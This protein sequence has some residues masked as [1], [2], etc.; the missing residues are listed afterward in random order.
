MQTYNPEQMMDDIDHIVNTG[1]CP[2]C[3]KPMTIVL[4]DEEIEYH[5]TCPD[6]ACGFQ[7]GMSK[8]WFGPCDPFEG[9]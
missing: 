1:C 2:R 6:P 3:N 8:G 7:A 9:I 5:M 4:D